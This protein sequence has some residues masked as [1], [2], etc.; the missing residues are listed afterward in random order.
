MQPDPHDAT[1]LADMQSA[2][3]EAVEFAAGYDYAGFMANSQLRLAVER[4][5]EIIGEAS[6]RVSAAFKDSTP[7]IS[8][9]DIIGQRN[10]LA[11][12]YGDV[13]YE[14][15]WDVVQNG[16]PELLRQLDAFLPPEA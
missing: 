7:Q 8:W 12:E 1:Y 4:E 10:I 6:R 9:R 11:H 16:L 15:I 5:I 3:R 13:D 2:A 14:I